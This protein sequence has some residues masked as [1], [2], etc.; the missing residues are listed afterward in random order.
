MNNRI[1]LDN[2]NNKEIYRMNTKKMSNNQAK[3]ITIGT[4]AV[5]GVIANMPIVWAVCG[6]GIIFSLLKKG[7][8]N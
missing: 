6:G 4:I 2:N 1:D 5:M 8:N 7:D 3:G